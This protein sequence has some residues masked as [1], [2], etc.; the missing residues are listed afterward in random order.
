MLKF[1]KNSAVFLL[2]SFILNYSTHLAAMDEDR[3]LIEKSYVQSFLKSYSPDEVQ[4]IMDDLGNIGKHCFR[5]L[6]PAEGHKNYVATAGGPGASKSTTLEVWLHN[7]SNFAYL[8]PDQRALKFMI[9]TYLQEF[10]NYKIRESSGIN[11][12][13]QKAY[14]KWR[15]GSNFIA[16]TLINEACEKGYNIAHGTT[17]TSEH[18]SKLYEQ[19]KKNNYK[20]TLLLCNS[21]DDNR[22]ASLQHRVKTQNFCQV[23]PEDV[24]NKGKM[25]PERFPVYFQY[26]DELQLYWIN[27]FLEGAVLGATLTKGSK[28]VVHND[29][30]LKSITEQYDKERENTKRESLQELIQKF[31]AQR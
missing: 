23:D 5:G 21:P 30:A 18:V 1:L 4:L 12:L 28:M 8:D 3:S 25:F 15:G 31:E 27:N 10:T 2:F 11:A 14:D 7:K 20:I 22:V 13:P 9:N 19:L 26:A 24:V 17:S 29:A 6:S 16:S